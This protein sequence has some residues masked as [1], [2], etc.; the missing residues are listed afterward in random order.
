MDSNLLAPTSN[1]D[2]LLNLVNE[3]DSDYTSTLNVDDEPFT[4]TDDNLEEE[5]CEISL[6]IVRMLILLVIWV[7][8]VLIIL[9]A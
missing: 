3:S 4:N 7:N 5:D 9:S 6:E 1:S 2:T 8:L